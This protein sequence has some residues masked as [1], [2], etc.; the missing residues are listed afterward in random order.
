MPAPSM[1]SPPRPYIAT[2]AIAP[3]ASDGGSDGG[4]DGVRVS[5]PAAG[6][7]PGDA[8]KG[9][10]TGVTGLLAGQRVTGRG[11]TEPGRLAV[12]VITG[13]CFTGHHSGFKVSLH[14]VE[15]VLMSRN[16]KLWRMSLPLSLGCRSF[17]GARSSQLLGSSL[18]PSD[19]CASD[20]A[21]ATA[22][23]AAAAAPGV[24]GGSGGPAG[25]F[26]SGHGVGIGGAHLCSP[27]SQ[28]GLNCLP[29]HI[30][31]PFHSNA[32]CGAG[33]RRS[34]VVTTSR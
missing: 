22:T 31:R 12:V 6:A 23:A 10:I 33:H 28:T 5:S 2:A 11:S 21:T 29:P 27:G 24:T 4:S 14:E 18:V 8:G 15:I 30:D 1:P 16:N 26:G 13:R 7:R 20:A 34:R 19:L 25:P 3:G 9:L 17:T 32:A